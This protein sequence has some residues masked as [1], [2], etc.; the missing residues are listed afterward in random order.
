MV[1]NYLRGCLKSRAE[2]IDVRYKVLPKVWIHV[3]Y[4]RMVLLN[5][6]L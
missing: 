4:Y 6:G 2:M 5:L 3:L 1:L